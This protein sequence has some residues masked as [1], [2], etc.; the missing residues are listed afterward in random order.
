MDIKEINCKTA[1]VYSKL[2]E[3]DYCINPYIGCL[4]G[5]V[6]CYACFMKRF[7]NHSEDWGNFLDIKVN[8]AEVL[9]KELSKE[10]RRSGPILLGSVTDAYQPIEKN[11]R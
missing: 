3:V 1:L 11:S 6:Y 9:K 2:P 7:T 8:S 4:H 5:C 10:N